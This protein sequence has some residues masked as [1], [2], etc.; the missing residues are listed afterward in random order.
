MS[1]SEFVYDDLEILD[2]GEEIEAFFTIENI[3]EVDGKETAQLYIGKRETNLYELK[4]YTKVWVPAKS[5]VKVKI[6]V[7]KKLLKNYD[8]QAMA[9]RDYEGSYELCVGK[10]SIDFSLTKEIVLEGANEC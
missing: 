10:N 4:G 2:K 7:D 8:P 3:S 6:T 1:Y 9:W 5:K